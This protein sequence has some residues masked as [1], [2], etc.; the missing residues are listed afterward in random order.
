MMKDNK[1][2]TS[3]SGEDKVLELGQD[4]KKGNKVELESPAEANTVFYTSV[5]YL[6]MSDD[7]LFFDR[8]LEINDYERLLQEAK[9]YDGGDSIDMENTYKS[10]TKY[11]GDDVL[12]E[13]EHYAVI[14][15]NSVGG[16][17]NIMRKVSEHSVREA[18]D[19][20]GLPDCPSED[21]KEVAKGMV[22]KQFAKMANCRMPVFE[23][24]NGAVLHMEYNQDSD[25]LDV[26]MVTNAGLAIKHSF[27]YEHN[28]SLETNLQG[29]QERLS[30]MPEYQ[31]EQQEEVSVARSGFRR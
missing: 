3:Q 23:M 16:T 1:Q 26:G 19:R 31:K 24:E 25:N 4:L 5:N 30:E 13:D 28:A 17:Y 21:V 2:K 29:V 15:N 11:P 9:E 8:L 27:A 22:A 10:P 7:T 18:I 6:Q 12:V 14:Y 20:Y